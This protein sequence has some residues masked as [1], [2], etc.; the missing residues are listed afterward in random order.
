M[1]YAA[2]VWLS[3]RAC[4][5]ST[6]CFRRRIAPSRT[7]CIR[8]TNLHCT[9][10]NHTAGKKVCNRHSA[11]ARRHRHQQEEIAIPDVSAQ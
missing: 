5:L 6:S 4:R 3:F 7:R 9:H 10:E 11:V 1:T 8:S 2:R